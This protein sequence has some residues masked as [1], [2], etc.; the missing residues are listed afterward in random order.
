MMSLLIENGLID[1]RAAAKRAEYLYDLSRLASSGGRAGARR[2]CL[3]GYGASNLIMERLM[4][5]SDAFAISR[6]RSAI[7]ARFA[8]ATR[9]RPRASSWISS[10]CATAHA[11]AA[12]RVSSIEG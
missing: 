4:F 9:A 10:H 1:G 8:V 7:A 12:C 6:R 11:I 2:D 5:S 3:L